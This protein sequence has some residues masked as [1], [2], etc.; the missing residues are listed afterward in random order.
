M[1]EGPQTD[2]TLTDEKTIE[3]YT[4]LV[5]NVKVDV[6]I[7]EWADS[8]TP[9]YIVS[10]SGISRTT[11]AVLEEIRDHLIR[12]MDV[13]NLDIDEK[14]NTV[15]PAFDEELTRQIGLYFP[16]EDEEAKK[17][18][19]SYL[20]SRSLGMGYVDFL[21][22]D[23]QLEEIAIDNA[24]DPIWVYH[25]KHG[26]LQTN[27]FMSSE[28]Q[29]K[30]V[31]SRIGRGIGRQI[32]TLNPLL[33]AFLPTG[34]RV[35]ATI[36][37]IT[38]KGNTITLRKFSEDPWTITKFVK[39]GTL[40]SEAAAFLWQAIQY[41]LSVLVVGGTA[42]GK[43]SML[44]ALA[45]FIPPN[46][47]II[48]IEDTREL[49]LASHLYWVPMMT[50]LPNAEGRG[51]VTMED[52]LIN[53]LRMRPDRILVGEVRRKAEAETMFEAIHTG[54]SCYGTFHA[55]NS[56]EAVAR[57]TNEP[58]DVPKPLLPAINLMLVQFRNRRTGKRR[59]L[60]VA[61]ILDD[62][63][64]SVIY[65]Y[66]AK[67][68]QVVKKAEATRFVQDLILFTG[69]SESELAED[70]KAKQAIIDLLVKKD[71]TNVE[72]LGK[73]IADYYEDKDALFK[74]LQEPPESPAT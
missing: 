11:E 44:N 72:T 55:N 18:L 36:N 5:R 54:H 69:L 56:K 62:C 50:R 19:R 26:W 46:Q 15:D 61:E 1:A 14:T 30:Q 45:N 7:R 2:T 43:T 10:I 71:I 31:A 41:E 68:D 22:K 8:Y 27:I 48:S 16:Y 58:V 28:D 17:I 51:Q 40:S 73:A 57:L 60:E 20:L 3:E 65:Q 59:T 66:D 39:N 37:P 29:I 53:S 35:N 23:E 4:L 52:L 21:L 63:S 32:N 9:F 42:S 6:A 34:E 67:N 38:P 13:G 25:R 49:R 70:L 12:K 74:R 24:T 47:R 64:A 33:D